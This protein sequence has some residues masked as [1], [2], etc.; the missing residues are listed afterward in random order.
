M[1]DTAT[2]KMLSMIGTVFTDTPVS[3]QIEALGGIKI[4]ND[5][6]RDGDIIIEIE[7]RLDELMKDPNLF[8]EDQKNNTLN[9]AHAQLPADCN[10]GLDVDTQAEICV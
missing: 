1:N 7:G 4:S 9:L 2:H 3:I 6:H 10:D 8:T 5:H